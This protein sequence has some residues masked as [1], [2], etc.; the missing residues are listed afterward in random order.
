MS[1][2]LNYPSTPEEKE[3]FDRLYDE[4]KKRKKLYNRIDSI[5]RTYNLTEDEFLNK[6]KELNGCCEICGKKFKRKR[7][8]FIDHSHTTGKV[9]GLLCSTCNTAL[10]FFYDN[11]NFLNS[12]IDYLKKYS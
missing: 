9:R 6:F 12:A 1:P 7:E 5:L 8:V 11:L 10:G 4:K 2:K 3:E